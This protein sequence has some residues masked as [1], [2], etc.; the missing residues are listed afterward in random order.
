[1]KIITSEHILSGNKREDVLSSAIE[2]IFLVCKEDK[3][4]VNQVDLLK[5]DNQIEKLESKALKYDKLITE[6]E[7][8][9]SNFKNQ[10]RKLSESNETLRVKLLES[11]GSDA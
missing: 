10:I 6:S 11:L 8:I 3:H 1:M 5:L 4:F 7:K 9:E 2:H